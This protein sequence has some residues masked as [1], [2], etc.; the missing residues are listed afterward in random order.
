MKQSVKPLSQLNRFDA[1][2]QSKMRVQEEAEKIDVLGQESEE[3]GAKWVIEEGEK[4]RKTEEEQEAQD[5]WKLHDARGRIITYSQL[6]LDDMKRLMQQLATDFPPNVAWL[7]VKNPKGVVLWIRSPD[8][9]WY[10]RGM[11]I[12]GT[13]KYDLQGITRL[14]HKGLDLIESWE[15]KEQEKKTANGIILPS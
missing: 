11:K 3:K 6:L 1:E 2:K 8:R 14:V 4:K 7:A 5:Q 15:P 10:A 13:P 9:E 12:C